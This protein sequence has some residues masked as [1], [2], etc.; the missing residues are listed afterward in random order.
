[1]YLWQSGKL[2]YVP[3]SEAS[4][5]GTGGLLALAI[6]WRG[7]HFVLAH[8]FIHIRA[9]YRFI[10]ALHHRNSDPEPFS[11]LAMHPIEHLYYF[12]G[13]GFILFLAPWLPMSPFV[14]HAVGIN[15]LLTPAATHS[16]FEDH[17][18]ASQ[19]HFM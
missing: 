1:M 19:A 9:L 8:R 10:H 15:T 7:I 6:V 17:I 16:G 4:I 13:F 18:F 2:A 3:D 14:L 11:G 12:S 5:F